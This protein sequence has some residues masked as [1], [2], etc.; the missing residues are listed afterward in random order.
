MPTLNYRIDQRGWI[1]DLDAAATIQ[2]P[3]GDLQRI[4]VRLQRGNIRVTDATQARVIHGGVLRLHL[5]TA[6]GQVRLP[7]D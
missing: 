3:V 5:R 6:T 7:S 1:T 4:V 2:V